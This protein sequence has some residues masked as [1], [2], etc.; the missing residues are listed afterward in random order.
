LRKAYAL[1]VS[2]HQQAGD[3]QA[4]WAACQEGLRRTPADPELR[5]RAAILLHEGGRLHEAARTYEGLLAAPP[6]RHF[7]SIDQGITGYKAR[8]NLAIVYQDLGDWRRATEQWRRVVADKPGY[9]VGWRGL[10]EALLR[11]G[12]H[13][14]AEAL[15]EQL[16]DGRSLRSEKWL[17][18]GQVAAARGDLD[19]ARSA[20]E[21]AVEHD[22]EDEAAW[23]TLCH[24]LF[25]HGRPEEAEQ[26]LK[27][28]LRRQPTDASAHHNLGTVYLRLGR[29]HAAIEAYRYSLRLRPHAAATAQLLE[30]ALRQAGLRSEA[31]A[32]T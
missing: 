21:Q 5:F 10:V 20:F 23:Q 32:N 15:L 30:V 19:A 27:E 28:L 16:S 1:L 26:A 2:C 9:R 13:H 17:L 6:E 7:S 8:Q 22:G 31:F 29:P 18:Q 14:E 12:E 11:Q 24:F 3:P 25:D 4:A